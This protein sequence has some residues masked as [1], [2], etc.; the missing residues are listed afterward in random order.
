MQT[1]SGTRDSV[2]EL[3]VGNLNSTEPA[4]WGLTDYR[5]G[6]APAKPARVNSANVVYI[7]SGS[8]GLL[9]SEP[10][11]WSGDPRRFRNTSVK[12]DVG[13]RRRSRATRISLTAPITPIQISIPFLPPA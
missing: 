10:P 8:K 4:T 6:S 9:N 5:P 13:R 11:R 7:G 3:T 1:P 12:L 2:L